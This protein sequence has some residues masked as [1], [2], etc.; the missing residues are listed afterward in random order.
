M[1]K[2]HI[3]GIFLFF[4]ML[5]ACEKN[6]VSVPIPVFVESAAVKNITHVHSPEVAQLKNI[7]GS[8]DA[9][10]GAVNVSL[11]FSG[12]VAAGDYDRDG[13]IDLYFTLMGGAENIMYANNGKGVFS[14]QQVPGVGLQQN[15]TSPAFVDLNNDGY[16]DLVMGGIG[17]LTGASPGEF[18]MK[19]QQ[20]VVL[21][22]NK[23]LSFENVSNTTG[24]WTQGNA[25]TMAFADYDK[26]GD[27]DIASSHWD[28]FPRSRENTL[29]EN[30]GKLYFSAADYELGLKVEES[31]SNFSFTPIFS[32][33]NGDRW[34]DLIIASD[35]ETSQIYHSQKGERFELATNPFVINDENGM[36]AASGD[37]DNDG[38]MDIFISSIWDEPGKQHDSWGIGGNRLYQNNGD[39]TF[40]DVTRDAGVLNSGWSWG[41]CF[42]DFNNDGYLDLFVTNGYGY[43]D[44]PYWKKMAG[45]FNNDS[46]VL[47]LNNQDG[48][49]SDVSVEASI[50]DNKLGRGVVCADFNGDG[51]NDIVIANHN[52]KVVFY[53]NTYK[54]MLCNECNYISLS[55]EAPSSEL[56]GALVTIETENRNLIRE[57]K[58]GGSFMSS[59]P[60]QFLVGIGGDQKVTR[61]LVDWNSRTRPQTVYKNLKINHHHKLVLKNYKTRA[62]APENLLN[63]VKE[64]YEK[65][66][67]TFL[68]ESVEVDAVWLAQKINE[69]LP[70]S[71]LDSFNEKMLI[72]HK[73]SPLLRMVYPEAAKF[74][75]N[76]FRQPS[77]TGKMFLKAASAFYRPER[78]AL[79]KVTE[80]VLEPRTEAYVLTHQ[81][82]S[83]MWAEREQLKLPLN[84]ADRKNE[85]IQA[86]EREMAEDGR[87]SDIYAERA[88]FLTLYSDVPQGT[89][90]RW[91]KTIVQA[92]LQSGE[93]EGL[94]KPFVFE[95]EGNSKLSSI[96]GQY[97]VDRQ[98]TSVLCLQVLAHYL[99]RH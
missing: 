63:K 80:F 77:K 10:Y 4:F 81:L 72:K 57:I 28:I 39:G 45:Q 20:P 64:S 33:L 92:Q 89:L 59:Q 97:R 36:G 49:F 75:M 32:D 12:G 73:N 1:K 65:G 26:D 82:L 50:T 18:K 24:L 88:A 34:L 22:N 19:N 91:V 83:L 7:K 54:D 30:N 16:L 87:F 9:S 21:I 71:R 68:Q 17:V 52:D 23:G 96:P 98:H 11:H 25:F 93:W 2:S 3:F 70:D 42:S 94:N 14:K 6:H 60:Y 47:Y 48:T 41:T 79:R 15:S 85:L 29:W 37:Y 86:I 27:I 8:S 67:A 40:I 44:S 69:Q 58:A 53:E 56:I 90:E 74:D 95:Y 78:E 46:S 66:L 5:L 13:D 76:E 43:H 51:D 38:D 62:S 61:I 99:S 35:F 31:T 55:F 84:I